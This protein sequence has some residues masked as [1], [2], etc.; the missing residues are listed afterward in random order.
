[1]ILSSKILPSRPAV[2]VITTIGSFSQ[3][4]SK[5][6]CKEDIHFS[7]AFINRAVLFA[8]PENWK[9]KAVSISVSPVGA[10]ECMIAKVGSLSVIS[11]VVA[12]VLSL[13]AG[14]DH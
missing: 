12:A 5:V 4:F 2:T 6:F 1:M 7:I 10:V 13:A 8:L 9:E 3:W 14:V 11:L